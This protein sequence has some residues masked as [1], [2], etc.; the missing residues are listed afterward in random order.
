MERLIWPYAMRKRFVYIQGVAEIK[1]PGL[2]SS[3]TKKRDWWAA[4]FDE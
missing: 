2:S 4:D 3:Y 1:M